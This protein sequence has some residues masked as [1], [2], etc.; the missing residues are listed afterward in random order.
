MDN[1]ISA[2][3]ILEAGRQARSFARDEKKVAVA[4]EALEWLKSTRALLE[5]TQREG[6]GLH[7]VTDLNG[8]SDEFKKF[9]F[10]TLESGEIRITMDGGRIR[11]EETG[12]PTL[13][14]MLVGQQDM[15]V[16]AYIP[17]VVLRF[18]RTEGADTIVEPEK[19]PDGLF[20]TPAIFSELRSQLRHCDMTRFDPHAVPHAVELSR[21]PLS[22]ADKAYIN[23]ILGE[24]SI[25][26]QMQGFAKSTITQ[27]RVRGL[28][29]SKIL[30]NAG[31]E[32]LDQVVVSPLPP[33]IPSTP[34]DLAEAV[35]K[36]SDMIEWVEID[37][38]RGA[39]G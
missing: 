38:S 1:V 4:R 5:K 18:S 23:E 21:E 29:R 8:R 10:D 15:I 19:K 16:T 39:I 36:L 24:G 9:L 22:P 13:W 26:V 33:E 25:H 12:V 32:L 34:D 35:K 37:I 2:S 20:A 3:S 14:R 17:E 6:G 27:T 30:N 31:R 11:M 7:E 28:W